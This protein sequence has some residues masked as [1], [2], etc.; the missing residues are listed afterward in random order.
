MALDKWLQ[1]HKD[2]KAERIALNNRRDIDAQLVTSFRYRMQDVKDQPIKDIVNVT[3][4][5]LKVFKAYVEASLNKAD[6][7][8]VV[9]SDDEK[10]D[11]ALIED[12]IK[13]SFLSANHRLYK[14]GGWMIEP[15]LDQQATMR[16]EAAALVLFQMQPVVEDKPAFLE[17]NITTWDTRFITYVTSEDG[18]SQGAY[19]TKKTKEMIE[20][21]AWAKKEN[22]TIKGKD[23]QVVDIW[24][25]DEHR[26]YV[27]N[28]KE[29]E[30]KNPFGYVPVAVQKVPIG[31]MLA[32]PDELQYQC[33]SI[34]FLVRE[35]INEYNRCV[36]IMQTHNLKA[37]KPPTKQ[38]KKGGGEPSDYDDIMD[39]GSNTAM[40]PE[41][42]I[43]PI[44]FG[45]AKRSMVFALQEI[46]KALD[47][48]TLSRITLGDLPGELSA[49]A[50]IQI[51][52]GQGQ[53][54]MPR[55]GTRGLLKE[56]ISK[57]IIKQI[58]FTGESTF[59]L[60]T[61]GHKKT[62]KV[63]DLEGEYGIEFRYANKSP[64]TDFARLSIARQYKDADMLDELTILTDIMKR[65]DPEGDLKNLQRQRLRRIS[66][67]LRIW[68]G[69]MSLSEAIEAGDEE[70]KV[71][72][73]IMEAELGASL[74]QV[75]AGNLPTPEPEPVPSA[76]AIPLLTEGGRS[77]AQKAADV[78]RTPVEEGGTE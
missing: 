56:Q 76:P 77:S 7:M 68:D 18:L 45:D 33:E 4:N 78:Q 15:F 36:S 2:V 46:N 29:F 67:N 34:F 3:M 35:L 1:L 69:L 39:M 70:A 44:D 32:G 47:D 37:I 25:P 38:K 65:D 31:S 40:E 57:M 63:S 72:L 9:E 54:F 64:E 10:L 75:S 13:A 41:E 22:F 23:A 61:P 73:D 24:R 17:T 16:G 66:P 48:G 43:S 8:V 30:E 20:S 52:Q 28:I 49:I 21:E 60:G 58:I 71:E 42:D 11:T 62:Y 12:V 53:V 26:V 5:R 59:E 27:N 50:L 14:R 74:A 55:L 19:E 6:E 51:E